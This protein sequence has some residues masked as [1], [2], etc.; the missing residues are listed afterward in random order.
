MA[1]VE[2][3]VVIPAY[4]EAHRLGDTLERIVEYLRERGESYEILVVDDGSTDRTAALAEEHRNRGVWTLQLATNRGKGGALRHGV[5]ATSGRRVLLTDADLSTPIE[6]LETLEPHLAEVDVVFGSREVEGAR[7]ERYQPFHRVF[8]G[9]LFSLF[10]RALGIR[11][12]RDTQCGFKLLKGGV[13]R[14]VFPRLRVNG[15]AYDVEMVLVAQR[16]GYAVREVGVTWRDSPVS[17]V[18]PLTHGPRMLLD[19][20]RARFG[21]RT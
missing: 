8:L 12:F 20:L 1:E 10:V 19:V 21:A 18:L 7:V 6:D 4:N 2:L 9:R 14:D 16:L 5:V 15:F 13:A 11:G 3:S 17:R